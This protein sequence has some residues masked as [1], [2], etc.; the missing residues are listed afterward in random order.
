VQFLE[1]YHLKDGYSTFATMEAKEE[2][3]RLLLQVQ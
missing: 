2:E 3:A 1:T